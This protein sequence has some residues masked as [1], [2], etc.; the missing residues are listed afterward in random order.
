M[1]NNRALTY[2][3]LNLFEKAKED[4]NWALRLNEDCLKSLLLLAKVN[5]LQENRHDFEKVIRE[6]IERNPDKEEFI[7]SKCYL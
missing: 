7:K 3:H 2:I 1:Y 5:L 6:A 4:L